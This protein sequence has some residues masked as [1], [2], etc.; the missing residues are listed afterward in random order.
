MKHIIFW[1]V[2]VKFMALGLYRV[3]TQVTNGGVLLWKTT[4]GIPKTLK[5]LF[6]T[7]VIHIKYL[8][9]SDCHL[10]FPIKCNGA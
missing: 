1:L 7:D 3:N 5:L 6:S 9:I 10:C 8:Y 4:N 2:Q